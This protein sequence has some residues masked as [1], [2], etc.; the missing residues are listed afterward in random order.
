VTPLTA[1]TDNFGDFWFR[2]PGATTD[3]F[4]LT[5]V[6]DGKSLVIDDIY[7]GQDLSLGDIPMKL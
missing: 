3:T 5:L 7:T 6:K 1:Q 2:G 4:T